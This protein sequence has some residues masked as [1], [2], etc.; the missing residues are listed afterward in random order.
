MAKEE[1][2]YAHLQGD[3]DCEGFEGEWCILSN[4]T[5]LMAM[6]DSAEGTFRIAGLVVPS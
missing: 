2:V 3:V 6:E 1:F 5:S 4:M